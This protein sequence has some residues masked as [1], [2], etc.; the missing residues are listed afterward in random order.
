MP[1]RYTVTLLMSFHQRL[2]YK[3]FVAYVTVIWPTA[4]M[5]TFVDNKGRPLCKF[6]TTLVTCVGAF[7]CVRPHMDAKRTTGNKWLS[8]YVTDYWFLT[9]MAEMVWMKW[10][11]ARKGLATYITQI[12]SVGLHVC[13]EQLP[14]SEITSTSSTVKIRCVLLKRCMMIFNVGIQ[15]SLTRVGP[16]TNTTFKW[17][18]S[19]V[20]Y[21][22]IL[23]LIF[24]NETFTTHFTFE[25]IFTTMPLLME[26]QCKHCNSRIP[27]NITYMILSSFV[28][29]LVSC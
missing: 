15:I 22:M 29:F 9:S 18:I 26:L 10:G 27:T 24:G 20:H 11:L 12:S 2:C 21:L 17:F 13:P 5:I 7:T 6:L 1:L 14:Q 8:T 28:H 19:W 25:V 3:G 4:C 16:S 23:Q